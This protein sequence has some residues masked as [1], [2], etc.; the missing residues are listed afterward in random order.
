MMLV[1]ALIQGRDAFGPEGWVTMLIGQ[2]VPYRRKYQPS[3]TERRTWKKIQ[4]SNWALSAAGI[5]VAEMSKIVRSP[6]WQFPEGFFQP[7]SA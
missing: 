4:A 2:N 5:G 6:D 3:E 7:R 1:S